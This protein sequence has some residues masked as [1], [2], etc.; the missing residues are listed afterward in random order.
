MSAKEMFEKLGYREIKKY[1]AGIHYSKTHRVIGGNEETVEISFDVG[2]KHIFV[3]TKL[4][5]NNRSSVTISSLSIKELEA[6]NKQVEELG[7]NE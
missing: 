2:C 4:E 7:W 6:I 3:L 1:W 5:N